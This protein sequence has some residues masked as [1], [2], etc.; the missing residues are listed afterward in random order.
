ME[1]AR[2]EKKSKEMKKARNRS[3]VVFF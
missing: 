2:I 3:W 1:L